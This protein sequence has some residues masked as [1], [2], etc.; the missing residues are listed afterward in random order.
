[1]SYDHYSRFADDRKHPLLCTALE[2][3]RPSRYIESN[4]AFAQH[5]LFSSPEQLHRLLRFL[6][7]GQSTDL[8]S[9]SSY[10]QMG[11]ESNQQSRSRSTQDR[12][13]GL[14]IRL[15]ASHPTS[16]AFFDLE[17]AALRSVEQFAPDQAPPI[18]VNLRRDK[19]LFWPSVACCRKSA[20]PTF[21][22]ST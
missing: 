2:L 4:S 18:A 16:F 14:A 7:R 5:L 9:Q 13:P 6:E 21:I 12:Q 8:P 1:M 10:Y 15:L 19:I 22:I 20:D 3:E 11:L 17:H